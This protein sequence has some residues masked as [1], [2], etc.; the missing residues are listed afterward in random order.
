LV[1]FDSTS[2]ALCPGK[3]LLSVLPHRAA[4]KGSHHCAQPLV[5]MESCELFAQAGLKP[6]ASLSLHPKLKYSLKEDDMVMM[7][8]A[9]TSFFHK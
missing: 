3:K 7:L 4:M 9:T 6:W 1:I 2:L 8:W 5:E